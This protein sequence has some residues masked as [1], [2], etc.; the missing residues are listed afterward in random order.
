M[1][2]SILGQLIAGSLA[3]IFGRKK[4][5]VLTAALISIGSFGSACSI[6]TPTLTIYGQI[7]LWRFF[8]GAGVGGEYPLAATV[9]CESSSAR[10]RGSLMAAVFSMQG[11]GSLL[12]GIV[13]YLCLATGFTTGFAWRFALAFGS[14]PVLLAFPWRLMMHET[15]SFQKLKNVRQVSKVAAVSPKE[16][17]MGHSHNSHHHPDV[18][19]HHH[20]QHDIDTE[21]EMSTMGALAPSIDSTPSP[22]GST[23]SG[24]LKSHAFYQLSELGNGSSNEVSP[25]KPMTTPLKAGTDGS[26]GMDTPSY[27]Q[28]HQIEHDTR[29]RT[30]S[31]D[32][33]HHMY[34][35][36]RNNSNTDYQR[37]YMMTPNGS[38]TVNP[39][40]TGSGALSTTT[41]AGTTTNVNANAMSG[42]KLGRWLGLAA[43][44]QHAGMSLS[45]NNSEHSP[46][47]GGTR[48]GDSPDRHTHNPGQHPYVRMHHDSTHGPNQSTSQ[49][50]YGAID[51][52][53]N[54]MGPVSHHGGVITGSACTG[55]V[56][57]SEANASRVAE[58]AHAFKYYKYHM[59]GTALSWFLLDIVFYGNGLFNHEVTAM[60]LSSST[61]SA[62]L[63]ENER[64]SPIA[65]TALDDAFSSILLSLVSIPG[66]LLSVAYIEDVGRKNIQFFG[67]LIMG[68]LYFTCAY[69]YD[70]LLGEHAAEYYGK[71]WFLLI[72]SLTFLFRSVSFSLS[73]YH[74]ID[75]I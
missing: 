61:T 75:M 44:Q 67:F 32:Y 21:L 28:Q 48:R 14:L 41:T 62:M 34:I 7:A 4:L 71:Y 9:T 23:D 24:M 8:L 18:H 72:Y 37:S 47:K 43:T 39:T 69:G 22:M 16:V 49:L 68:I 2:G 65:T 63:P 74:S 13:V 51:G 73:R 40:N 59:L 70:Y 50:G 25:I 30:L 1:I 57:V 56:A 10:K 17:L 33:G 45:G 27:Y 3:D 11:A 19:C 6:D 26:D 31:D 38:V 52:K 5:F 12:S 64:N 29:E 46:L 36:S 60:V 42:T 35:S 58:L 54:P 66:Y 55:D 53:T 20:H 15:E